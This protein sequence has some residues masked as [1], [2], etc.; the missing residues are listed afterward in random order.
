VKHLDD[1]EFLDRDQWDFQSCPAEETYEARSDEY[2][3]QSDARIFAVNRWRKNARE[4]SFEG[5]MALYRDPKAPQPPR[6]VL[7]S[8]L[9]V[10]RPEWSDGSYLSV[11]K[12]V[13]EARLSVLYPG[14]L[15][16]LLA[17]QMEP[18]SALMLWTEEGL[19]N[20]LQQLRKN[21][22]LTG[23]LCLYPSNIQE[24]NLFR[25]DWSA[26][27]KANL[28][29]YAAWL[30][31]NSPPDRK[32]FASPGSTV[33]R[34]RADLKALGGLRLWIASGGDWMSCPPLYPEHSHWLRAIER[35]N[36]LIAT[37]YPLVI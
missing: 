9:Y 23:R 21:W 7:G 20:C 19:E 3:R 36:F 8:D 32:V 17:K 12:R 33:R 30:Q 5:Y 24:H 28:E 10:V 15:Q 13:R 25:T 29:H 16:E 6:P 37:T 31:V 26:S 34:C 4:Q 1:C 11:D 27:D 18:D 2:A 35:A 22:L 14:H